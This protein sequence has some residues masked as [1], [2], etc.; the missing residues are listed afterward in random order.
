MKTVFVLTDES[1]NVYSP[2]GA[3]AAA[4][5]ASQGFHVRYFKRDELAGLPLTIET[6][7]VGGVGTVQAALRR[8]G[9][10]AQAHATVPESLE[11]FLGRQRSQGSRSAEQSQRRETSLVVSNGVLNEQ[12]WARRQRSQQGGRSTGISQG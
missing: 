3:V 1:G 9:I 10:E 8:L 11:A 12:Y 2:N 5:F 6:P 4:G 7:V